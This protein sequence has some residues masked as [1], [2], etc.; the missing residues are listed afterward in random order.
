MKNFARATRVLDC[1]KHFA[2]AT[3]FLDGMKHFARATRVLDG[4]KS[5]ARAAQARERALKLERCTMRGGAVGRLPPNLLAPMAARG[6][7]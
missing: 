5:F 1:M 2:R 3:R 4:M 6:G 7:P